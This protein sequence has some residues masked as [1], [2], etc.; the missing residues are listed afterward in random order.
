MVKKDELDNV[1]YEPWIVDSGES[2]HFTD[3]E[4]YIQVDYKVSEGSVTTAGSETLHIKATG[5]NL[6]F[7]QL[8]VIPELGKSLL[9]V[10]KLTE[11]PQLSL[12]F[13]DMNCTISQQGHVME[14]AVK[15]SENLYR[16]GRNED[17]E[18][19]T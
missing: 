2:H 19:G 5:E 4:N 7:G 10:G 3:N 18:K 9:S 13:K 14:R 16:N 12:K 17:Q 11:D 6:K 1:E 8:K 15:G